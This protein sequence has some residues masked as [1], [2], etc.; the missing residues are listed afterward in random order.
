MSMR[1]AA[2]LYSRYLYIDAYLFGQAMRFLGGSGRWRTPLLTQGALG[3]AFCESWGVWGICA[4]GIHEP[5][6]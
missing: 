1:H 5:P 3:S 2:M 4:L 6:T